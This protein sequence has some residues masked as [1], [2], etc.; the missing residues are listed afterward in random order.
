MHQENDPCK[1]IK[2]DIDCKLTMIE[3]LKQ[4]SFFLNDA[5]K[6]VAYSNYIDDHDG[7]IENFNELLVI[8]YS[9]QDGIITDSWISPWSY[10][11]RYHNTWKL[12]EEN[13]KLHMSNW[14]CYVQL[15]SDECVKIE[16][17]GFLK[18]HPNDRDE[19]NIIRLSREDFKLHFSM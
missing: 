5:N 8:I 15:D 10:P 1:E 19:I 4:F 12:Y 2:I 14:S 18:M 9:K 6:Y 16:E 11:R 3:K 7:F 13:N 17:F